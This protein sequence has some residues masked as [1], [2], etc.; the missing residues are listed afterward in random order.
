V[1]LSTSNVLPQASDFYPG[2]EYTTLKDVPRA[3]SEYLLLGSRWGVYVH[4]FMTILRSRALALSGR[5]DDEA[6]A[7]SSREIINNLERCQARFHIEGMNRVRGTSD[8][9][10]FV[11]NH[12]STLETLALP[13][14]IVP[15]KPVT[16]VVKDKLMH[17]FF[18]GPIMRSRNPI[19]VSRKDARADLEVV[20]REGCERLA[21]GISVIVF[22]Q[23]SRT[24]VFDRTR[25][26]SLGTKLAARAGARIVPVAVKTDF[27]G[28]SG[29]FHGFG[30]I[31]RERPIHIE[32]GEPIPVTG[33][34]KAEH[35]HCLDFIE[36]RLRAWGAPIA[37]PVTQAK[38]TA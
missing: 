21:S 2:D 22:P 27:W 35:E 34:G 16:Y 8:P 23:G 30:P 36:S 4:F 33:R 14:L 37:Q 5:Y 31:H 19:S 15:M 3:L 20:L 26:N 1:S 38:P 9:F 18:W 11:S 13:G 32:F 7:R 28:S 29:L 17:G 12:M 6:W 25:F 10:V 24:D